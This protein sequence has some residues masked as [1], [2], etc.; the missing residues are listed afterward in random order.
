MTQIR[1]HA[2]KTVGFID[3]AALDF[4]VVY[5]THYPKIKQQ[6]VKLDYI[7]GFKRPKDQIDDLAQAFFTKVWEKK[8]LN[9]FDANLAKSKDPILAFLYNHLRTFYKSVR[10]KQIRESNGNKNLKEVMKMNPVANSNLYGSVHEDHKGFCHDIKKVSKAFIKSLKG[11]ER[12]V[13]KAFIYDGTSV[14]QVAT[15]LRVSTRT[16]Y[17]LKDSVKSKAKKYLEG[18]YAGNYNFN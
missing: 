8:I 9:L 17:R 5:T 13:W 11:L 2:C 3:K 1:A 7:S 15:Q 18:Y 10:S 4:G 6:L 14:G 12:K 16:S